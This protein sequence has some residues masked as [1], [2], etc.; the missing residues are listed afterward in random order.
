MKEWAKGNRIN[1]KQRKGDILRHD[2][3][4]NLEV[5]QE[6]RLLSNEELQHNALSAMEFEEVAINEEIARRQRSTIQWHKNGDKNIKYLHRI[7]TTYERFNSIDKLLVDE[8]TV[9]HPRA[10]T[11]FYLKLYLET[12][13]RRP[14]FNLQG[15]HGSTVK[16]KEWM[17]RHLG[18]RKF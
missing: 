13:Q 5:S 15:V 11:T 14:D 7:S 3:T 6:Q 16:K 1:G 18:K 17:Q 8:T 4:A 12:E 9:T 10:I 2:H